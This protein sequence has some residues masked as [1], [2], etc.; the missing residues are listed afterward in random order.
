MDFGAQ[1]RGTLHA[2]STV[3][4]AFAV[5]HARDTTPRLDPPSKL[6]WS[7][8]FPPGTPSDVIL[9]PGQTRTLAPGAYGNISVPPAATLTL[10]TGTYYF[11]S[12][13]LLLGSTVSLNQASGPVIVYVASSLLPVTLQAPIVAV[14]GAHPDLLLVYLGPLPIVAAAQFDG[15]IVAPSAALALNLILDPRTLQPVPHIGFFAAQSVELELN[16]QVEYRIPLALVAAA[17]PSGP[18]CRHLLTGSG[19]TVRQINTYCKDCSS[20]D[21]TDRDGVPDCVD[22]CPYDHN[23]TSPGICGCNRPDLDSDGDGVPDC[24]EPQ[25][26]NDPNNTSPGQCGC[27]GGPFLKPAGTPCT[28]TACPQTGAT[29][30]GA[31]VCG[32]RAACD[33][34]GST[35]VLLQ[36]NGV[37]YWFCGAGL[38]PEIGPDGGVENAGGGTPLSESAAQGAC[39]AKGLTLNRISTPDENRLIA[40]MLT[41]PAWLGANDLATSGQWRW[42]APNNNSGDLFWVGGPTGTPQNNLYSNWAGVAPGSARC[43]SIVPNDGHWYDTNCAE[44]LGYV[45]RSVAPPPGLPPDAG[46]GGWG[47]GGGGGGS[48]QPVPMPTNCVNEF[49]LDAGGLPD[50]F[51]ELVNEVD[52]ARH[53]A[54]FFGVGAHRPAPDSSCPA[55]APDAQPSENIG[56]IPGSGAGC[57]LANAQ[58]IPTDGGHGETPDG[59]PG[60]IDCMSDQECLQA[61]GAGYVCRQLKN[62]S[63]CPPP[64]GGE[65]GASDLDAGTCPGHSWCGQISCPAVSGVACGEV[66]ICKPNTDFDAGPD[67]TTNLDAGRFDPATLFDATPEASPSPQYVD[68]PAGSGPAHTWCHMV[69]TKPQ[70]ANKPTGNT[71]GSSGHGSPISFAFD[72]NL[73]FAANANPLAFGENQMQIHAAASLKATV[74]LTGFLGQSYSA[75]IVDIG[76]G[77]R[78]QRC[79]VDND[80]TVFTVL[81]VDALPLIGLGIPHF[82]SATE[83]PTETQDCNDAVENFA[84]WSDRAKKAFRDAQ[85]LLIQYAN[86]K[87]AG[88][89]FAPDLCHQILANVNAG[90]VA[91]FPGGLTCPSDEPVEITINRFVDYLQA[92]G[93]GQISQLRQAAFGLVNKSSDIVNSVLP[94]LKVN[95]LDIQH[96]ESQTILNV[97]FAIGPVPM[98]LQIDVFATYGINGYFDADLKVPLA[99]IA[100]LDETNVA[101]PGDTAATPA[102][103]A[104]LKVN[105]APFASAGVSAF[106]G[107]GVD[108]GAIS[109]T[110]GIEGRVTLGQV[111]APIYAGAGLDMLVQHDTRPIPGDIGPVQLGN[112]FH[113]G[114]PKSFNFM[115]WFDYGAGIQ[116]S[117]ILSGE[118]DGRLHIDFVFFGVDWR[119]RVVRFNGWS[120]YFNL[121]S[122][123]VGASTQS[124]PGDNN[125]GTSHLPPPDG[126]TNVVSTGNQGPTM[127]LS[128]P[129]VPL[130]ML[131]RLVVPPLPDAG[132]DADA[133]PISAPIVAFDASAV[134]T[135]FY[136]NQCCMRNPGDSCRLVGAPHCCPDM[137]CVLADAGAD[138][139]P[140]LDSGTC[141]PSCVPQGAACTLDAGFGQACCGQLFCGPSLTCTSCN[142]LGQ[143]CGGGQPCCGAAICST[144]DAAGGTCCLSSGACTQPTDCCSNQCNHGI[145]SVLQ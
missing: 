72:P 50:T 141:Q 57:F 144:G 136:D 98:V 29:C 74:S 78:A 95:F 7:V 88:A 106:V 80:E 43:A 9:F 5:V 63:H 107:A 53:D 4:S 85:Q 75:D 79:S 129:Q 33:P 111:E 45:C 109:A 110:I 82:D 131:Q 93:F 31:G 36:K 91:L 17:S 113:F 8:T 37:S 6:S 124:A 1:V 21:D 105:V 114:V 103:I 101:E 18:L 44:T 10:S 96:D 77:I 87:D 71:G 58:L 47:N 60:L 42:S 12:L 126:S 52:A 49:D 46:N 121:V 2:S 120:K 143:A 51:A 34:C 89:Q 145:C 115:V 39:S 48:D 90:D 65:G 22:G 139:A 133:A 134:Q 16:A 20:P 26:A 62:D 97:P 116:L 137:S 122:G 135:F 15:A 73:T 64:D 32:N 112:L 41:G 76:A 128:E 108:L 83:F 92:P 132:P 55:E 35:G 14:G 81:G 54:G 19:L 24:I 119:V 138:A 56:L 102:E 11:T 25:C 13:T 118:I 40:S 125:I 30:N 130:T 70:A 66:R 142:S 69:P 23:K 140:D 27:V 84:L 59:G 3:I 67:P 38:P 123:G 117:N 104:H 100:G 127:G 99:Q 94:K 61:F 68:P 86:A 28:D